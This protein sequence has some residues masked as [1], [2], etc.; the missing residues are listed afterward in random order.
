M[1]GGQRIDKEDEATTMG[2]HA[3]SRGLE[4][5]GVLGKSSYGDGN[6]S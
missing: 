6:V 4:S 1:T 3:S 5:C 2:G